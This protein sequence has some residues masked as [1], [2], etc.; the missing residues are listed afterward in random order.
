M[1]VPETRYARNR[2]VHIAY[3]VVGEGPLALVGIPP[4]VSNIELLWEHPMP[5]R[6]LRRLSSF[7]RFVHYDKR[8]QGLSDRDAGSP[9]IDDRLDDLAAVLDAAGLERCA[10]AGVSEGGSTAA[11][12]A[13]MHPERVTHLVLIGSFV[14]PV[15]DESDAGPG[16]PGEL[17]DAFFDGW[18]Q[19]WGTP[20]TLTVP[21]VAPSMTGDDAFLRWLNRFER[22]TCSP[23]GLLASSRWVRALDLRPLLSNIQ[24]PTLVIHRTGDQ[25]VSV[26]E[27]RLLA[28][29]VPDAQ[30]VELDGDDHLPWTGDQDAVL[31]AMEQFLVGRHAVEADPDRV[32]ATVLFTDIVGSTEQAASLGDRRWRQL[33]DDHDEVVSRHVAEA[34][35]RVVKHTGDGA[36]ATFDGPVRAIRCAQEM[37]RELSTLG[38]DVRAGIHTGEVEVRGDDIGGLAVHIGARVGALAG[39]GEVYVSRTVVD[40]VTGAGLE[41]EDRGRHQLKGVPG[42]WQ[43]F[44]AA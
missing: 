8:G 15:N 16:I 44:A 24:C 34:R 23:G 12:F 20:E 19:S 41:F 14:R 10:L 4:I 35:G 38:I 43:L 6:F 40:L 32:L 29:A 11:L 2:D 42:E 3:Q 26:E 9:S 1:A 21:F 33:L 30:L 28:R 39:G 37:R 5:A 25:M 36:L 17:Y 7:S 27:S 13:A 18:A 31:D 22:Q